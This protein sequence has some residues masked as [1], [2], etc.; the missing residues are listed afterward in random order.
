MGFL[1]V[2]FFQ[3]IQESIND[4][5]QKIRLQDAKTMIFKRRR[6]RRQTQL[7]GGSI[8]RSVPANISISSRNGTK[9]EPRVHFDSK[10]EMLPISSHRQYSEEEKTRF[11]FSFAELSQQLQEIQNI[12]GDDGLIDECGNELSKR[13]TLL[14][15]EKRSG[16]AFHNSSIICRRS[17]KRMLRRS[18]AFCEMDST[19]ST[20]SSSSSSTGKHIFGADSR[21]LQR[22]IL[23]RSDAF[24]S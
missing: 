6:L 19:T 14:K 5:W 10:V 11:W 1:S 23:R 7:P 3:S 8:P 16:Q 2:S 15:G 17:N 22:P 13:E 18:D 21:K 12:Q 24:D 9:G 20:T 4:R